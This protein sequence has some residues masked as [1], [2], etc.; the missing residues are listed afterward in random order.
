[1]AARA[2]RRMERAQ[3]KTIPIV[4][5]TAN[6]FAED[7]QA[8]LQAGMDAQVANPLDVNVLRSVLSKVLGKGMPDRNL[9]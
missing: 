6:A 3:A 1:E 8:A 5:M 2:I 7:V 4:A 9:Q